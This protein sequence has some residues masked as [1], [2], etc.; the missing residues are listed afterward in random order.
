MAGY[1]ILSMFNVRH[2]VVQNVIDSKDQM[3]YTV[4]L[5][6]SR[7]TSAPRW[8]AIQV[9]RRKGEVKT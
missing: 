7:R 8:G 4:L 3:K 6:V 9:P 1:T 2:R 5:D